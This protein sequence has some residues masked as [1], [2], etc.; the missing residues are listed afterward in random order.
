MLRDFLVGV[1]LLLHVVPLVGEDG[2]GPL[3][4]VDLVPPKK[5]EG[6]VVIVDLFVVRLA[7]NLHAMTSPRGSPCSRG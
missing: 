3:V 7:Y 2:V 4:G 6:S 5:T 1:V